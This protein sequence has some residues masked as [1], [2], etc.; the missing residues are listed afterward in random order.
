MSICVVDRRRPY[1]RAMVCTPCRDWLRHALADIVDYCVQLPAH[2]EPAVSG[3]PKVSGTREA[4]LPLVVDV[5]DLGMPARP[6]TRAL[7]ARGLLGLDDDQIGTLSAAT[8]LERIA[9][10]WADDLGHHRPEPTVASLAG[11]LTDRVDWACDHHLAIDEDAEEIRGLWKDLQ[12]AVG[13]GGRRDGAYVIGSCPVVEPGGRPCRTQL[14][15][16]P[17]VTVI[18]CP[19]CFTRWP[20]EQWLWL[21]SLVRA[22]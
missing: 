16:F 12:R 14:V 22:A 18:E 19:G 6:A 8:V 15:G 2:I 13:L 10:T 20:R 4:Q 1:E 11:W 3:G 7:Q 5:L 17:G 21:A 9:T